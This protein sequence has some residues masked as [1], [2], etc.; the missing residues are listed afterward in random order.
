MTLTT[1]TCKEIYN[2][3]LGDPVLREDDASWRHG[4]YRTEV[5]KRDSDNT[6]WRAFY[7]LSTDRE[8]NGLREGDADIE[9]VWPIEVKRIEYTAKN[10][11]DNT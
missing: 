11:L 2:E 1:P 6:F 5:Y 8:T 7:C 4:S 10:P 9:Q 3:E